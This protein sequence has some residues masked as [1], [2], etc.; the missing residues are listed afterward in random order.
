MATSGCRPSRSLSTFHSSA[1]SSKRKSSTTLPCP[2]RAREQAVSPQ[3]RA[4]KA[5]SSSLAVAA[6]KD[7]NLTSTS[8]PRC[9]DPLIP[10]LYPAHGS[11][12]PRE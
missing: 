10:S 11:W 1:V 4:G 8:V 6:R 5:R 12:R 7:T 9:L 3:G 2:S